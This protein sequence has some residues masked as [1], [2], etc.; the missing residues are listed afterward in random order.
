MRGYLYILLCSNGKLY[1]GSTRNIEK[2]MYE[3]T[4]GEGANFTKKH[5][6]VQL[7]YVE[8]FSRIDEAFYREK[9]V[10]GWS[11]RK[12]D[13]LINGD[14]NQLPILSKNYTQYGA[15]VTST[16][17][18][19]EVGEVSEVGKV[20]GDGE[21]SS[22]PLAEPVEAIGAGRVGNVG[23]GSALRALR[24]LRPLRQAQ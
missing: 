21:V 16:G 22:P 17:S 8:E 11:R 5:L 13:A 4:I 18:V 23:G 19:S 2:R 9:Q 14:T 1:T 15:S 20:P 12:K 7:V 6:P 3:H 10:Q 24:S